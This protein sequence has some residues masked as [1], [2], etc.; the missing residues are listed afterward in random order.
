MFR[1]RNKEEKEV[2]DLFVLFEK[3]IIWE[4]KNEGVIFNLLFSS[5]R[6]VKRDYP[7][8]FY[9]FSIIQTTP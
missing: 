8:L 7:L 5:K 4:G 3:L 6:E 9:P 2:C 1:L